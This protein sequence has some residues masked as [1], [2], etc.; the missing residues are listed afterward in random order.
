MRI[1]IITPFPEFFAGPLTTSIVGRARTNG[2]ISIEVVDLRQWGQGTRKKI[3]DR[4]FGGGAGMVL[5]AEPL[6]QALQSVAAEKQH[7]VSFCPSG[8]PLTHTVCQTLSRVENLVLVCGAYEGIDARFIEQQVD[9]TLSIG[10]FVCTSGNIPALACL[11]SVIRW[12]PGVLGSM[13]SAETDSFAKTLLGAPCYTQP[14]HWRGHCVPDVLLS[15]HSRNIAQ[16]RHT[17]SVQKTQDNRPALYREWCF[18]KG[19]TSVASFRTTQLERWH[20]WLQQF[21]PTTFRKEERR[22]I[23]TLESHTWVWR[24]QTGGQE[25]CGD[26]SISC[27]DAALA[28]KLHHH[29]LALKG[30]GVGSRLKALDDVVGGWCIQDPQKNSW[31]L[32]TGGAKEFLT[33]EQNGYSESI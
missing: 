16:F 4:P 29:F 8:T 21:F 24:E 9:Q 3:D 10:D 32:Y 28:T 33:H 20:R 26:W 7:V 11:D 23:L 1:S 5:M 14:A 27:S 15:G 6:L 22:L 17:A 31:I 25:C 19:A 30:Q 18:G 13:E 12:V 2:H